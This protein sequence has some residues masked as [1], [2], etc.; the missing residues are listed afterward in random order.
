MTE[1]L[2]DL[3]VRVLDQHMTHCEMCISWVW[4]GGGDA[5]VS[6]SSGLGVTWMNSFFEGLAEFLPSE[7][8]FAGLPTSA[9]RL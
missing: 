9:L 5:F 8:A 4:G 6:P 7:I 2:A 1:G 3:D